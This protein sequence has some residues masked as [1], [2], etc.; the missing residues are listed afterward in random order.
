MKRIILAMCVLA[1]VNSAEA[2]NVEVIQNNRPARPAMRPVM[3]GAPMRP[4]YQNPGQPLPIGAG[5][6]YIRSDPAIA[7]FNP[8]YTPCIPGGCL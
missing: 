2:Q 8:L 4:I 5:P 1:T 6:M 3:P 7:Y